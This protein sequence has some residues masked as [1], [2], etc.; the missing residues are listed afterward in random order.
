MCPYLDTW[1]MSQKASAAL[2]YMSGVR[3]EPSP[4]RLGPSSHANVL[5]A[6]PLWLTVARFR[7]GVTRLDVG[8]KDDVEALNGE[9][10]TLRYLSHVSSSR[11]SFWALGFGSRKAAGAPESLTPWQWS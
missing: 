6:L 2:K 7:K 10:E 3:A 5:C 9:T 8:F 4:P 11:D 1:V